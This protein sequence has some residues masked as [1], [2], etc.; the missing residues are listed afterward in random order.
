MFFRICAILH[1]SNQSAE[2]QYSVSIHTLLMIIFDPRF[3]CH[4]IS[5]REYKILPVVPG[6]FVPSLKPKASITNCNAYIRQSAVDHN[7]KLKL[8]LQVELNWIVQ[9]YNVCSL[10]S[11]SRKTFGLYSAKSLH[12]LPKWFSQHLPPMAVDPL[13]RSLLFTWQTFEQL[14]VARIQ[15]VH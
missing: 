11:S 7:L 1:I 15:S 12:Y 14:S 5:Q 8:K 10:I 2:Q 3:F 9:H 6:G 13:W 4:Q